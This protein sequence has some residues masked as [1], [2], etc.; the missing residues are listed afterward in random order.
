MRT[1]LDEVVAP[2]HAEL[3]LAA[4]PV[5]LEEFAQFDYRPRAGDEA[6]A[7]QSVAHP[8]T[9]SMLARL[10]EMQL[11][12]SSYRSLLTGQLRTVDMADLGPGSR[13]RRPA[14]VPS[15]AT[16]GPRAAVTCPFP[17]DDIVALRAYR[18]ARPGEMVPGAEAHHLARLRD[19]V[20]IVIV[21]KRPT[22]ATAFWSA[23]DS[24]V[25]Q[26][27]GQ[28][29]GA[30][31]LLDFAVLLLTSAAASPRTW[32]L[33]ATISTIGSTTAS[34]DVRYRIIEADCT[35]HA[36]VRIAVLGAVLDHLAE[37]L[38]RM[39]S[40][41]IGAVL[42][43][44]EAARSLWPTRWARPSTGCKRSRRRPRRGSAGPR[45]RLPGQISASVQYWVEGNRQRADDGHEDVD[46]VE[47]VAA[48]QARLRQWIL[49]GFGERAGMEGPRPE[50]DAG[51]P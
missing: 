47:Q 14:T 2:Y 48:A 7:P 23:E 39:D 10:R 45:R 28:I 18:P 22:N 3:G 42:E 21:V 9:A 6:A 8:K 32:P 37:A 16:S 43:G 34:R 31:A 15:R 30:A 27:I 25:L 20:D 11:A 13:T 1:F 51:R 46:F 33:C 49:N 38:P 36:V 41:V 12:L 24:Q 50:A 4:A 17:I 5:T 19:D 29:R 40:A 35:D 26:L 44:C